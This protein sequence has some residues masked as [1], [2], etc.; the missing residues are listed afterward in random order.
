MPD[1]N[2]VGRHHNRVMTVDEIGHHVK[3]WREIE[4]MVMRYVAHLAPGAFAADLLNE[5]DRLGFLLAERDRTPD[6]SRCPRCG[7]TDRPLGHYDVCQPCVDAEGWEQ[8]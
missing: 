8:P 4:P 5:I 3:R 6:P 1:P 2:L 7:C